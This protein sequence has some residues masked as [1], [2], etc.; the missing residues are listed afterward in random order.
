MEGDSRQ[1]CAEIA[2][3]VRQWVD[4]NRL[5]IEGGSYGDVDALLKSLGL[6]SHKGGRSLR[7]LSSER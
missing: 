1:A 6:T 7:P 4:E 2:E 3:L 5:L